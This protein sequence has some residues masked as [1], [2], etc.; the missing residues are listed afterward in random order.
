MANGGVVSEPPMELEKASAMTVVNTGHQEQIRI[1][2]A[3]APV[4]PC[5]DCKVENYC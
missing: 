2:E 5:G 1:W 3:F 4:L